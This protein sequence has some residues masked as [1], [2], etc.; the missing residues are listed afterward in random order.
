[1]ED[2]I[3]QKYIHDLRSSLTVIQGYSSMLSEGAYG[4]LPDDALRA[5][6]KI[7]NAGKKM[8]TLL[9]ELA[10]QSQNNT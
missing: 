7:H 3:V 5:V 2:K 6:G 10:G 1:M 9:E 4:E 8:G